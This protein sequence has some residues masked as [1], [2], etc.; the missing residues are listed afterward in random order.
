MKLPE[1]V[2][3]RN[4]ET[5]MV[6]RN[7]AVKNAFA[8]VKW[9]SLFT[10]AQLREALARQETQAK[11]EKPNHMTDEAW[12]Q[13]SEVIP[14]RMRQVE[15]GNH[16]SLAVMMCSIDKIA[17]ELGIEQDV[18]QASC[19]WLLHPPVETIADIRCR[20]MSAELKQLQDQN[21]ALDAKLASHEA[22]MRQALSALSDCRHGCEEP[23]NTVSAI[24]A[25]EGALK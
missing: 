2:A 20:E 9:E 13:F 19:L 1:P 16:M 4:R 21:T 18:K 15:S 14:F 25:L 10:E 5:G 6:T 12:R 23:H 8:V 11:R 7:A 24:K 3:W 17:C 22:V